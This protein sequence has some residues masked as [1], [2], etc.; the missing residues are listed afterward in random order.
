MSN[1]GMPRLS[2]FWRKRGNLLR[3][4]LV[5]DD[6]AVVGG[7]RDVVVDGGEGEVG[8]AHLAAG[9]PQTFECLR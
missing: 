8:P 1:S 7:S 4:D 6:Q 3:R 2:Q 5:F 9:E